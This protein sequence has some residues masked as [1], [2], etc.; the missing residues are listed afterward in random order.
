MGKYR[1]LAAFILSIILIIILGRFVE[2]ASLNHPTI[3]IISDIINSPISTA[4]YMWYYLPHES[5]M[6]PRPME[7]AKYIQNYNV[8]YVGEPEDKAIYLTFDDCPENGNIPGILDIL[9]K[10]NASAAFFMTEAYIRKHPD[11]IRRIV[12]DGNLVCNHTS[13]HISVT[14][15][16]FEK[17]KAELR[18]V[19]EAYSEVTGQELPKFFRPP[20]GKF[21]ELTLSYAEQ[22]GYTTVFWSFRYVD[23]VVTNQP[24]EDRA[25]TTIMSET[26]PGEIA[27]LH[28]Q[29]KT[30]L[31]VLDKVLTAWE[32]KGYIFKSLDTLARKLPLRKIDSSGDKK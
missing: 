24:S 1:S 20:Q 22:L 31:R 13:H 27:L 26:H 16:S 9:E 19:E 29:S 5:E 25:F 3:S 12:S 32:E 10:H 28:S 23:W 21:T 11:I 6:Q 15:L 14:R 18:G 2:E 30:N 8:L 17:F 4:E 7:K